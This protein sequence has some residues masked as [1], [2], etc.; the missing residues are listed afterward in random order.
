MR[1]AIL[2]WESLHSIHVGGLGVVVTRTA[3]ELARKGHE[4]YLFTIAA[5][6]QN[7]HTKINDVNY[8]RCKFDP[9]KDIL[10]FFSNMSNAMVK[11]LHA[12]A[13]HSGKFDIV[14][15]H[16]WHVADA[17]YELKKEGNLIVLS[18]HSSEYGRRGGGFSDKHVSGRDKRVFAE[19][20]AREGL[21]GQ[22]SDRIITVSK[23]MRKEL[24]WLYKIPRKKVDIISNA[25]DP[26]K[27]QRDVDSNK[28]KKKYGVPPLAPTVLFI[29]RLEYQKGPDLLIDAIPKVLENQDDVKFLF[30]GM[31]TMRNYLRRRVQ[32]LGI[33]GAVRFLGWI[34]YSRY[35]DLLNTC[36]IVCIP[37]RNEPFGIVLLEAW[38]TGR[39]IVATDVGGLGENIK[40]LVDG[41]KVRPNPKSMARG[42]NFLFNHPRIMARVGARGKEKVIRFNWASSIKKLLRTYRKVLESR[43]IP[44]KV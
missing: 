35:V 7:K 39:P 20:S 30:A 23:T 24:Y 29:G 27:Y 1:I 17:L 9:G 42:I 3:E 22:I 28:V 36:D 26:R 33:V 37:S 10:S 19:I 41:I 16:D 38:A 15:G 43:A 5:E 6:G 34:P 21:G 18:Y 2:A 25:I 14:H 31:G 8:C 11:E 13:R 4:V 12:V 40:N 32:K 44:V